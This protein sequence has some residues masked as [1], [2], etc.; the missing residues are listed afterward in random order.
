VGAN[1]TVLLHVVLTHNTALT[2]SDNTTLLLQLVLTHN[3]AFTVG[4][5]TQHCSYS[6][7]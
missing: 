3:T 6:W 4:A 1:T 7:C 2:V 5:N